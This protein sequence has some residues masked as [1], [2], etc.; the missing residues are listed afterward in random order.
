MVKIDGYEI[1]AAISQDHSFDNE[2]TEHPVEKGANVAD[3][4]RSTP[5]MISLEGLVSDTPIGAI[6][7]TRGIGVPSSEAFA[8][9]QAIRDRRE[10]VTIETS[11]GIFANMA[12]QSLATP[13]TTTDA[14]R[15]LAVFKQIVIVESKRALVTV[16]VPRAQNKQNKGHKPAKEIPTDQAKKFAPTFTLKRYESTLHKWTR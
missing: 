8:R 11:L 14:L 6:A 12:L 1:D 3:H 16:D 9:L 4:V 10:P 15:F 7:A 5:I 2:I 13:V